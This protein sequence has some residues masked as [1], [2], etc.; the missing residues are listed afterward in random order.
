MFLKGSER[1]LNSSTSLREERKDGDK[2]KKEIGLELR[3]ERQMDVQSYYPLH[4]P[5][6]KGTLEA[7]LIFSLLK[8]E[9]C[10]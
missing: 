9:S 8:I 2:K 7:P 5:A 4:T 1:V 3:K 10:L 6:S